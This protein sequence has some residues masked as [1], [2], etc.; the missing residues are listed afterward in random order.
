MFT[1]NEFLCLCP[2]T[3][4]SLH[5]ET[6]LVGSSSKFLLP[7]VDYMGIDG[8]ICFNEF[9]RN[10]ASVICK[11]NGYQ[12]GVPY[13]IQ[14][15]FNHSQLYWLNGLHCKGNESSVLECSHLNIGNNDYCHCEYCRQSLAA[16][17]CF[18]DYGK[19][20]SVFLGFYMFMFAYEVVL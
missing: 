12:G 19:R 7:K 18:E 10:D 5:F 3:D 15:I 20:L 2:Y 8:Y 17:Y 14:S 13:I 16:V 1:H 4:L 11:S 6:D 9:D